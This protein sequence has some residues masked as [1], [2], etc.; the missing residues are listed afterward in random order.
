LY[1]GSFTA[2]L[3]YRADCDPST[4][5]KYSDVATQF[6]YY[7]EFYYYYYYYKKLVLTDDG[8]PAGRWNRNILLSTY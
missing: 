5:C 6:Y 4:T 8:R 1:A 2:V 3:H 7:Y